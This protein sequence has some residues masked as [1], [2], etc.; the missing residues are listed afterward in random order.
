MDV[1]CDAGVQVAGRNGAPRVCFEQRLYS[2][3]PVE[4]LSVLRRT[5]DVCG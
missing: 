3:V 4:E 2:E 1:C 5:R